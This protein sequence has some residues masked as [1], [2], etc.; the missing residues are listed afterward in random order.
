MAARRFV[1]LL[2]HRTFFNA[3]ELDT[4]FAG[5][6]VL[7]FPLG[8]AQAPRVCAMQSDGKILVGEA[9]DE[10]F[11]LIRINT[12]GTLDTTFGG[13]SSL[14]VFSNVE[15]AIPQ[16]ILVQSDGKIVVAGSVQPDGASDSET[17]IA[18]ARIKANGSTDTAFGGGDGKMTFS[19]G[20]DEDADS[21]SSALIAP[22][23]KIL[24]A[25]QSFSAHGT[26]SNFAVARLTPS[27]TLDT[28]F[29]GI[30]KRT[31]DFNSRN[32]ALTD[33][34]LAS[35]GKILLSGFSTGY[36]DEASVARLLSDGSLDTAFSSDGKLNSNLRGGVIPMIV[37]KDGKPVIAGL[38][39]KSDVSLQRFDNAGNLESSFGTAG[40]LKP[41]GVPKELSLKRFDMLA[42]GRFLVSGTA[43][44][45]TQT[46]LDWLAARLASNYQTDI[47]FAD[48]GIIRRDDQ[49]LDVL[50]DAIAAPDGSVALLGVSETEDE[51]DTILA[52]YL[53][54]IAPFSATVLRPDGT[55]IVNGSDDDDRI[56][57]SLPD[58][59]NME[60]AI[61]G[62]ITTIPLLAVNRIEVYGFAGND[63]LS[64]TGPVAAVL[65]GSIG[66]DTLTG[67]GGQDTLLGGKGNDKLTGSDGRDLIS[68]GIGADLFS[69][70][71]GNIDSLIGG[72]GHDR[73]AADDDD[74]LRSIEGSLI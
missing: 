26:A 30:G 19:F 73:A 50:T 52:R 15:R 2:E 53:P 42:D 70:L 69:A 35:D 20:D 6:G 21:I 23:G 51:S 24:L 3:G 13:G 59:A 67:G 65:E 36:K 17:N 56:F 14:I 32:D 66:N 16:K 47:S 54:D 1:D 39:G 48:N 4:R 43:A 7:T 34:R 74:V 45:E 37:Q 5:D 10:G 57:L 72:G 71:D 58:P 60:I 40:L 61:N 33:I 27:G 64:V 38:S 46:N 9:T 11:R 68:G 29:R 31:I 55:L 8:T 49:A 63:R 18:V 12:D 22:D 28:G 25:G 62:E 44:D 41:A